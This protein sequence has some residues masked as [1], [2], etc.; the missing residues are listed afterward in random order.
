MQDKIIYPGDV[1]KLPATVEELVDF[2]IVGNEAVKAWKNKVRAIEKAELASEAHKQALRDGQRMGEL[3]LLAEAKL[4]EILSR[5]PPQEHGEDGKFENKLPDNINRK[6]SHY[7]QEIYRHPEVMHNV[8]A[9]AI[10][11]NDI[12]TKHDVLKAIKHKKV[13]EKIEEQKQEIEQGMQ[14]PEGLYDLIVIDP[15]WNYGRKYDAD[16]ARVANQYP[17]M[18]FEELEQLELPAKDDCILWCWT[19]HQFIYD[20]IEL[21]EKWGFDYKCILTWDKEKMGIGKWLRLQTEFCLL[22]IRG[23]P[24]WEHKNIRD[25][26]REPRTGHSVKPEGFYKLID[27]NF[28]GRKLDYFGRKQREGWCVYGA[29]GSGLSE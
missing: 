7:A 12:P 22:G 23:K 13:E 26:I 20:A 5:V 3:V 15:P 21:L 24:L 27:E 2:V 29:G 9:K 14:E 18:S 28:V 1:E 25:I 4:G 19:T 10:D 8:I 6:E 16:G 11:K 17:E